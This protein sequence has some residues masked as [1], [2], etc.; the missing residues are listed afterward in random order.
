MFDWLIQEIETIKTRRFH[1]VDGPAD[2][3]LRKAVEESDAPL[4]RSYKE[5]ARRFGNAK[6]YKELGYYL[7][8]VVAAP[9]EERD[10]NG[11]ELY[12]IGHYQSSNA[13][14]KASLLRGEDES[15]VFE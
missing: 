2:P 12:R 7:V 6:L 14:F 3:A 4:P 11:E 15:P 1:V 8:G 13:Y 9:R 10:E 5:F